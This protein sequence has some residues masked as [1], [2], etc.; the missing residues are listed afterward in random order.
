MNHLTSVAACIFDK[1]RIQT[2]FLLPC[3][4][5]I[6]RSSVHRDEM[7]SYK[8]YMLGKTNNNYYNDK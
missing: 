8:E 7:F 2:L 3:L 4:L 5:L 1:Q 6:M